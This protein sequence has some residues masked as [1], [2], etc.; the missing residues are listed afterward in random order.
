MKAQEVMYSMRTLLTMGIVLAL[1]GALTSAPV[2]ASA[3]ARTCVAVSGDDPQDKAKEEADAYKAWYDANTAKDY[4][5]AMPLAKEYLA[6]FPDGQYAAY[7]KDKWIPGMRNYMFGEAAKKKDAAAMIQIG[8]EVLA[9]DPNNLDYLYSLALSLGPPDFSHSSEAADYT[10]R[11]IALIEEGKQLTIVDKSK[12]FNKTAVL[13]Y[14]YQNLAKIENNTNKNSPRAFELYTKAASLDPADATNF[15]Q[16]GIIH[17]ARYGAA[18]QKFDALPE[19]DRKAVEAKVAD[20]SAPDP[21]P[22]VKAA[23]DEVNKEADAV[24]DSWAHFMALTASVKSTTRDQ[25][26][27]ALQELYKYR[28]ND[29]IEGL[30][31][32]ID[33]YKPSSS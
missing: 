22:E 3:P 15:L 20:A 14:L 11:A 5:K 7:L 16:L 2:L 4:A 25:V 24:I 13:A 23:I 17:Q 31:K 30:Q 9:A 8:N 29:K 10:K 19:A 28:H 1:G 27:K 6:K 26:D 32:L 18:K 12:P 33:Q 21:K